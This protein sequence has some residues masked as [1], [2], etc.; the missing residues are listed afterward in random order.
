MA[1][2]NLSRA[3]A[4][5]E[6]DGAYLRTL[7]ADAVPALLAARANLPPDERSR[8]EAGLRARWSGERPG[9]WRTWNL[10]DA[11][12]R[13]LIASSLGDHH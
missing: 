4:G 8:I 7:G 2:V 6:Y 12:A 13:A 9:G 10:A 3:A 11:R 1:R 5:L